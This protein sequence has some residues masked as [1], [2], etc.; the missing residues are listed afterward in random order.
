MNAALLQKLSRVS[1]SLDRRHRDPPTVPSLAP[2][3]SPT[4]IRAP[5]AREKKCL[6]RHLE[7]L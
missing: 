5:R 4:V 3:S 6:L 7:N 2:L 1:P